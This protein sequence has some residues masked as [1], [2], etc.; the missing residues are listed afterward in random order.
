MPTPPGDLYEDRDDR[1]LGRIGALARTVIA[2]ALRGEV[3]P[4]EADLARCEGW[5]YESAG[6]LLE[7]VR[8]GRVVSGVMQKPP[9]RQK[10]A[11]TITLE[12]FG[13]VTG[14]DP[15]GPDAE[16]TSSPGPR[17]NE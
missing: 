2:K 8:A 13:T 15:P 11:S 17:I 10:G 4:T 1:G 14:A 3:V 9:R 6:V 12:A 5:E 16:E 7:R